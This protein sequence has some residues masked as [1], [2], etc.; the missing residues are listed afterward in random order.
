M[1]S[2]L[3]FLQLHCLEEKYV[4][5]DTKKY[6]YMNTSLNKKNSSGNY[7]LIPTWS[8][9]ASRESLPLKK[10]LNWVHGE[11]STKIENEFYESL[12]HFC[13]FPVNGLGHNGYADSKEISKESLWKLRY[14]EKTLFLKKREKN[15]CSTSSSA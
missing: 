14:S 13:R 9:T 8:I 2:K 6:T 3:K 12:L 5:F 10:F 7:L 15:I 4:T 1:N 11:D